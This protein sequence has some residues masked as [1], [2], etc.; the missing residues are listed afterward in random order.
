MPVNRQWKFETSHNNLFITHGCWVTAVTQEAGVSLSVNNKQISHNTCV[1]SSL[2]FNVL[3]S[4]TLSPWINTTFNTT[5]DGG[6]GLARFGSHR[7]NCSSGR[8]INFEWRYDTPERRK[9][10]MD[11]MTDSVPDGMYIV[12]RN[13]TLD[14]TR[15][16]TYPQ[17]WAETW[18]NDEALYG[19]GNSLYHYLKKAGLSS[20]DSFYRARPFAL[21]YKKND[22]SFIPQ[23]IM[24]EGIYDNPSLS[25]DVPGI[26]QSGTLISPVLGPAKVWKEF[27][28]EG[29]SLETPTYDEASASI[30]G[31]QKNGAIDTLFKNIPTVEKTFDV[32]SIDPVQ[33]PFLQLYM[34]NKDTVAFT[35]YQLNYWQLYYEPVPEGAIA[36]NIYLKTKDTV[37]IGSPVDFG[38]AFKNVSKIN[39]DSVKVKFTITDEKNIENII[40]VPR[41]NS[42]FC[43]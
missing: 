2:V 14:P 28:W 16:P 4:A 40:P 22:P 38:I 32:S 1:F 15:F 13:F 19:A 25:V 5:S 27:K 31:I 20:I 26:Q 37:T 41:Q 12:V 42:W 8:Q 21:V 39:F 30:I 6:L 17:A 34:H 43:S 24:G 33:Y 9:M 23:W 29:R 35:P 36:P 18:K 3:D 10:M 7:N 11:F